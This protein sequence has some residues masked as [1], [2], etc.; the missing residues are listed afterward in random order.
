MT[1][2]EIRPM[3]TVLITKNVLTI[4]EFCL[5]KAPMDRADLPPDVFASATVQA[6]VENDFNSYIEN[7]AQWFFFSDFD[8]DTILDA[9]NI[10]YNDD[11]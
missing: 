6:W 10:L 9:I 1:V 4:W 7:A 11:V 8:D 5:I 2:E 3:Y